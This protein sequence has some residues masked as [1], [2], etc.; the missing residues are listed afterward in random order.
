MD[1]YEVPQVISPMKTVPISHSCQNALSVLH[2]TQ[3]YGAPV[4]GD[5]HRIK[6]SDC[7]GGALQ[8]LPSEGLSAAMSIRSFP[9]IV[10]PFL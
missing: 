2:T 4:C 10:L 9:Y 7:N 6:N 3:K 8:P 5:R 1:T